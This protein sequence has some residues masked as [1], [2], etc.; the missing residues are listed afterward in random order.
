[1][2]VEHREGGLVVRDRFGGRGEIESGLYICVKVPARS[3]L[4]G[5]TSTCIQP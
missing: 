1:M 5:G 3:H 2:R 4:H